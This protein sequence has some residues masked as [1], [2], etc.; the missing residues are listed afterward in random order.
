M[1]LAPASARTGISDSLRLAESIVGTGSA[2]VFLI[3][4]VAGLLLAL[5]APER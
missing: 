4:A 3:R 1:A 5:S 2:V